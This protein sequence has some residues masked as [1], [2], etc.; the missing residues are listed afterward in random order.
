MVVS[1]IF[2]CHPYLQKWSNLT[3]IFQMGWNHQLSIQYI[4]GGN[5][6]IFGF[7]TPKIGEAVQ[8]DYCSILQLGWNHQLDSHVFVEKTPK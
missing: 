1:N 5:S 6:K 2:Y 4:I 7:F 8:F 3:N